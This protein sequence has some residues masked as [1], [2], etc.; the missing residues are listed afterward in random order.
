MGPRV[1]GTGSIVD[2]GGSSVKQG[3]GSG[4]GGGGGGRL[5]FSEIT[6]FNFNG[7]VSVAGG[8]GLS[9][10]DNERG[11]AGTIDWPTNLELTVGGTGISTLHMGYD[12]S[13]SY[14][15]ESITVRSGGI[16]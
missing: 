8:D 2:V 12:G 9:W 14:T 1:A 15:F 10:S 4:G 5:D 7:S 16:L 11:Y 6:N 13:N 3:T